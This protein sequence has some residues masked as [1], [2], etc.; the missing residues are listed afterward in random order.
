MTPDQYKSMTFSHPDYI[1]IN[2]WVIPAAWIKYRE[3]MDALVQRHPLLFS[4]QPAA[5]DYD[6]VAQPTYHAGQHTDAWGCVWSNM[7]HGHEAIVTHHPLP[8]RQHVHSLKAPTKDAGLPHGFMYLR[9]ADLRG[10][11]ELMMDFA[12][13]APELQMLIDIVRDYNLRQVYLRL[14]DH[15]GKPADLMYFGDDLGMQTS[16]P[17]G[18]EKW[19]QYLKPCF[20]KLY[21][22]VRASGNYI[23]MHTDGHIH[24]IIP[25]L[26]DCGVQVLNPQ[27]RANGLDNLARV[28]KGKVCI[29]LDLDR[30]LFPY[31]TPQEL[32]RHVRD[33][34]EALG[35]PD[36]GLWLYAEIDDAIPLENVDAL[37]T[38]LEKYRGYFR[39]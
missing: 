20:Q 23:Y 8:T 13:D 21:A 30:Q 14:A 38:A 27:F 31:A 26:I 19:R 34:I 3:K 18:P 1:P 32:D 39:A 5:R 2:T 22:P 6:Q 28:A 7:L 36:G 17:M 25:D 12:E 11:E 16:L 15:A 24:E 29:N 33:A 4:N 9:L 37:W 10:F 35:S